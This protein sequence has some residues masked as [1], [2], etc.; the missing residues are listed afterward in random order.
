[1]GKCAAEMAE[2][3][4]T[5]FVPRPHSHHHSRFLLAAWLV[6]RRWWW[7]WWRHTSIFRRRAVAVDGA[8][9]KLGQETQAVAPDTLLDL[10]CE[11]GRQAFPPEL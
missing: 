8:V 1:M 7:W 9:V 5:D 10:P 2:M 4:R 3:A 6:V 11:Q